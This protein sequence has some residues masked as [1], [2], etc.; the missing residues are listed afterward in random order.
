MTADGALNEERGQHRLSALLDAVMAV[1]AGLD[2]AEVL[3]RII[4]SACE[5]VDARYGA[6]GVLGPDGQHLVEFVTEGLT[7]AGRE[8]IGDLPKG[9][10]VLGLL[11]REPHAVRLDDLA[12]HRDSYGFPTD[13]PPMHSFL[14]VPVRIRDEVYGNLYLTEKAGGASFTPQDQA[15]VVALAGA[16]GVA[17][18]NAR[19]YE[20]TRDQRRWMQISGDVS[21]MLLEGRDESATMAFAARHARELSRAELVVV[22]LFNGAGELVVIATDAEPPLDGA[23]LGARLADE[24]WTDVARGRHPILVLSEDEDPTGTTLAAEIRGF[25]TTHDVGPTAVLPIAIGSDDIGVMVVAWS[26]Q[27]EPFVAERMELLPPLAHQVSLALLAA[28]GQESRALVALLEDRDRI[29]RDMHDN[30]IQRLFATGL[31]LQSAARQVVSPTVRVRLDEGVSSLDEAIKDIRHA[32]FE[33][34]RNH[35]SDD[36]RREIEELVVSRGDSLGFVPDLVI[37]GSLSDLAAVL[38]ADVV[39]VVREGL[40]NVARHAQASAAT[41]SVQ[42]TDT[43]Q[44]SVTDNGVGMARPSARS[45]LANLNARAAAHG[46]SLTLEPN[47]P[48]GTIVTWRASVK[49]T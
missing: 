33:L 22:A 40:A 12:D 48:H 42:V 31:S 17:I 13:H 44:V 19:L 46:G 10:G 25:V 36:L 29:A 3:T 30:V 23:A 21:Q 4:H 14:G 43:V 18:D 47:V 8:A 49:R 1:T 35:A 11:I 34:H 32:I 26:T 28:R 37:T 38:A 5:L 6:M 27:A 24:R 7:P 20:R 15:I 16:A 39:A 41:V 2:L 9:H 45:G